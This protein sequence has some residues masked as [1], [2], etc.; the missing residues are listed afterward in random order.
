MVC[1]P[2]RLHECFR[3]FFPAAVYVI[4]LRTW[5]ARSSDGSSKH[6]GTKCS[7]VQSS[8]DFAR[9]PVVGCLDS[10]LGDRMGGGGARI[11]I[12]FGTPPTWK[13]TPAAGF[14]PNTQFK[15]FRLKKKSR[16]TKVCSGSLR[17]K[18]WQYLQLSCGHT[19]VASLSSLFYFCTRITTVGFF[20]ATG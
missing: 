12:P 8:G 9:N 11:A 20:G 14:L 2:R 7:A 1:M 4:L 5:P 6:H 18:A 3:A 16:G 13:S 19:A 10:P 17:T 15:E